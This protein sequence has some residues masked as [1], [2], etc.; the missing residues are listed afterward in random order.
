M[1]VLVLKNKNLAEM[2]AASSK[3]IEMGGQTI[4]YNSMGILYELP[5]RVAELPKGVIEWI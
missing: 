2:K 1:L 3:I 5:K 4:G